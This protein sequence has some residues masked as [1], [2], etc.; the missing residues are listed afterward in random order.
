MEQSLSEN[1][2]LQ[3]LL[4]HPCNWGLTMEGVWQK[5]DELFTKDVGIRLF[6][7]FGSEYVYLDLI[8]VP[9][10]AEDTDL[11]QSS[12]KVLEV[13]HKA[14]QKYIGPLQV[15]LG[16][17]KQVF[18]E[19][20]RVDLPFE[21][22]A[23]PVDSVL[24]KTW[25][26]DG[27]H[28]KLAF[29]INAPWWNEF[30]WSHFGASEEII[31]GEEKTL[32]MPPVYPVAEVEPLSEPELSPT[33]IPT[34][35]VHPIEI[36][37]GLSPVLVPSQS[38]NLAQGKKLDKVKR[39]LKEQDESPSSTPTND[40]DHSDVKSDGFADRNL[41]KNYMNWIWLVFVLVCIVF[42]IGALLW[43][44]PRPNDR[45]GDGEAKFI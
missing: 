32:V 25:L 9:A 44:Y 19:G 43:Y 26:V 17:A 2:H 21:C 14:T 40:F 22:G 13:L 35:L 7:A 24:Y 41:K 23:I 5:I 20:I 34:T 38:E 10:S 36:K 42:V 1:T 15:F 11:T 30:E 8:R 29:Y 12:E 28:S 3:D 4:R 45:N 18:P 6:P 27:G 39:K 16:D 37:R 31:L 33:S